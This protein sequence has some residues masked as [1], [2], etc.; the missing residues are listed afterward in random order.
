MV[1]G[2]RR[3]L[4]GRRF[5]PFAGDDVDVDVGRAGQELL[6]DRDREPAFPPRLG[7]FADDDLGDVAAAGEIEQ[8][9]GDVGADERGGFGAELL[10][11]SQVAGDTLPQ[12]G[13]FSLVSRSVDGDGHPFGAHR[14]GHAFGGADDLGAAGAGADA[15]EQALGGGPGTGG[16]AVVASGVDV[17]VQASGGLAERQFAQRDQIAAVEEV[18]ERPLGLRG[19]IDFAGLE[20]VE[21]LLGRDV[22]E[23]DFVGPLE[24]GVGQGFADDDVGDLRDDVVQAFDVLDVERG[25]DVDAGIEQLFDVFPALGVARAFDVGVG[26]LVDEDQ[27]G[28]AGQGCV[29][30]EFA[31]R[32]A[33]IGNLAERDCFETFEQ[34]LGV[35]AAVG[36]D[37]ADDDFDAGRLLALGGLQHGEGLAD[38]GGVA[39]EDFELAAA[40]LRLLGLHASEQLIGIGSW[41][42]HSIQPLVRISHV[43]EF[44]RSPLL[45][46]L[47]GMACRLQIDGAKNGTGHGRDPRKMCSLRETSGQC[48]IVIDHF[49]VLRSSKA[50]LSFS[51]LTRGSPRMPKVRSSVFWATSLRTWS[52]E[53]LRTLATRATWYS[54][55]AGL[56]SGSRPL[57]E[58][59]TRSIGTGPVLS[60]CA[61]LIA[62]RR[63]R[64]ASNWAGLVGPRLL[65]EE[66]EAS[67]GKAEV[68]DGRPQKY[69]GSSNDWPISSEPTSLPSRTIRL[70]FAW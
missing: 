41:V 56:I 9:V 65:P 70:P 22:D 26:E 21:E 16:G 67:F 31:E 64:T 34:G 54:A 61:F 48:P 29:Q 68:A 33:A 59:V 6:D 30:I 11:E 3:G 45:F 49:A 36:L 69:F 53:M 14:G 1:R 18:V 39:E 47:V 52:S 58:A 17:A 43:E 57:A 20:A 10:G 7:G 27:L 40:R 28:M 55:A 19:Q 51:T 37:V 23:L 66:A 42:V 35:A 50:R 60:G 15:D 2:L 62:S 4:A 32:D 38:A 24:D 12:D 63:A 8:C 46:Y 44:A 5:T 13:R 25:P